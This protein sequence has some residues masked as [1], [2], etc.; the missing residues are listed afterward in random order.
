MEFGFG[1]AAS[2]LACASQSAA[3][4]RG[5]AGSGSGSVS[6]QCFCLLSRMG[7]WYQTGQDMTLDELRNALTE[8]DEQLLDLVARR[9]ALSEQVA[10]VKRATG[11]ATR[12]FGRE[13]EV[14]LRGRTTAQRLGVSPD[15]AESLLRQLIQSSL[16]TQEHARVAAHAHGSGKRALV[17][18]GCGKMGGWFSEFLASQGFSVAISDPSGC[19]PGFDRVID[20]ESDPLD[21][22]L[23]VLATP[24]RVT[25]DLLTALAERKPRGLIFDLG[26][27]KT[28]LRNGLDALVTAGCRVTSLHPMFG[29]D[30]ELLSGRHVI[31]ID[32]GNPEALQEAQELF[33]PT[34]A[35]RVVMGL[36]EHDRLIAYVLGL[37]HAL[38]I[39]FFTALADSGEAAP[40]L[41][42]LS[43]TTFDAQLEVASRVAAESPD[44]YFEIQSLNDYG[45]ESL[46]ALQHAVERLVATVKSGDSAEF[47]AIMNRGRA[48][49]D[50][51]AA[52][53]A[54]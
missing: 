52:A 16:T 50:V 31:F 27:L 38:N 41:A 35:E 24:L 20:W 7:E 43:S 48:Y 40:R 23:I 19:L 39:A 8:L 34:M 10:S 32:L 46:P 22:D 49:L 45:G 9:Q 44:L 5:L 17:I 21:F 51:R 6:V 26:S 53:R 33:A 47:T 3:T 28:P 25:G 2:V 37:S 42:R 15:L 11:R 54:I 4:R 14:I 36:D 12:D 30:T 1:C 18:G 13:R 29:P